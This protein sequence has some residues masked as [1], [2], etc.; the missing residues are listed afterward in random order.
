M[1]LSRVGSTEDR[2]WARVSKGGPLECWNW[3]GTSG[4]TGYGVI[5]G[6]VG[7][8]RLCPKGQKMLAHR[9]S[10]IMANGPI[11][12][13]ASG[14]YHGKVVMHTCD[15][16][17]CVNPAH[18]VLGTQRENI[19]DMDAKGRDNRSGL[20]VEQG[21]RHI[22]AALDAEQVADVMQSH[23]T[24]KALADRLGVSVHTVKRLRAGKTYAPQTGAAKIVRPRYVALGES[25]PNATLSFEQVRY[26]RTSPKSSHAIAA[27]IGVS[28][29]C[30]SMARR[31]ASYKD[32]D[33]PIPPSR[34]GRMR[35]QP[36]E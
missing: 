4:P 26:I 16:R 14:S 13:D 23:E 9:V 33:V 21:T 36:Q 18:L 15:N 20:V 31:G 5:A 35:K 3:T 29:V 7:G 32:V 17:K 11:P 22:R 6:A 24:H 19:K 30:V 12:E 1:R 27:E 34:V 28:Q 8:V 2:F 10:W 25:N